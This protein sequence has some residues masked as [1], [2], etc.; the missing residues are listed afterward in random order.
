MLDGT[1][2]PPPPGWDPY[3][4]PGTTP[5]SLFSTDP[6]YSGGPGP[7]FS[8]GTMQRLMQAVKLEYLWMPGGGPVEMGVNDVDTSATF[9]FPFLWNTQTPLLV[10]PGFGITLFNGP[11]GAPLKDRVPPRVFDA[12]LEAGWNPQPTPWFGGETAFRIGV[13]SDFKKVVEKSIRFQGRGLAALTFSPSFKVKVGVWYLDRERIKLLPAGG[14]VWTPNSE[15]RFDILFPDPKV[16]KRL[17]TIGTTEWWM[18]L[19]GEYGGDSW[20]VDNHDR[21]RRFDYNDMRAAVGVEFQRLGGLRGMFE[22]GVAFEREVYFNAQQHFHLHP[23]F[24]LHGG[25]IY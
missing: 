19:R 12:Y 11:V 21:V 1:I 6:Y 25:L 20:T 2:Q 15:V 7:T 9:A 13:Y 18:Y 8:I 10:T 16:T 3:A 4:P 14:I 5:G 17:T 22:G 23:C 24:F